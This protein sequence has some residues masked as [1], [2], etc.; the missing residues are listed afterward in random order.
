MFKKYMYVSCSLWLK[1]TLVV[2]GKWIQHRSCFHVSLWSV[3]QHLL[4]IAVTTMGFGP[5]SC[6][7]IFCGNRLRGE[8]SWLSWFVYSFMA[9]VGKI[10]HGEFQFL[11]C[12]ASGFTLFVGKLLFLQCQ[13]WYG[14]S[15]TL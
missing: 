15:V 7:S 1:L 6:S 13:V 3:L 12:H 11:A 14:Q 2:I 8:C 10:A 5:T 9:S 4:R